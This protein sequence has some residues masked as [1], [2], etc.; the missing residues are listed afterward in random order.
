MSE[1]QF[2]NYQ[3]DILSFDLR[4]A[5]L[6]ILKPGRY[7]GFDNFTL[8]ST[9]G[10][11]H[12]IHMGHST[13]AIK[14]ANSDYPEPTLGLNTGVALSPQGIV[15]HNDSTDIDLQITDGSAGGGDRYDIIYMQHI[16]L[17]NTAGSNPAIYGVQQGNPG[18]GIPSLTSPNKRCIL[19]TVKIPNGSTTFAAL[20]FT[21]KQ[22]ELGDLTI[23]TDLLAYIGTRLYTE[24]NYIADSES[25]TDSLD[26]LDMFLKDTYD[27]LVAIGA[28]PLD[29]ASWGALT[30]NL[31]Q[32]V[33]I[34]AHGL[35]PK[36]PN[37]STK[38]FN[39]AGAWSLPPAKRFIWRDAPILADFDKASGFANFISASGYLDLSS[40]VPSDCDTIY[41]MVSAGAFGPF[42]EISIGFRKDVGVGGSLNII[43]PATNAGSVYGQESFMM[44]LNSSKQINWYVAGGTPATQLA[45]IFVKILAWNSAL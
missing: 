42:S 35:I 25:V 39:G 5:M 45:T 31:R 17:P 37:D 44:G 29:S 3:D 14:K 30:D 23:L 43:L 36:L 40:I 21:P 9:G 16:Y 12:N 41:M 1:K 19:A 11:I 38:F 32:N 13:T 15:V 28:R 2:T 26:K 8:V 24:N 18:G 20:E 33:S 7:S 10:G 4:E 6:G 27:A 22:F 34:N